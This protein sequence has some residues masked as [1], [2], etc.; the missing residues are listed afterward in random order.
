MI[1]I[2]YIGGE[3]SGKKFDYVILEQPLSTNLIFFVIN[4]LAF[5]TV[6]CLSQLSVI[7]SDYYN[8]HPEHL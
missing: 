5:Q 8:L 2:H 4:L 1:T 3:G 7:L 6:D